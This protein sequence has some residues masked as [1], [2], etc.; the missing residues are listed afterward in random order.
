MSPSTLCGYQF[1]IISTYNISIALGIRNFKI[2]GEAVYPYAH[3]QKKKENAGSVV[4]LF[5]MVATTELTQD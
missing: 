5:L 4:V 1:F 2:L 3:C